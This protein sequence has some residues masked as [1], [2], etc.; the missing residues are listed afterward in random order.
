VNQL[1]LLC[2]TCH[3]AAHR[4]R[5]WPSLSDLRDVSGMESGP[6][7]DEGGS[8]L[9]PTGCPPAAFSSHFA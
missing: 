6:A 1:A 4:M 5:P 2:P 7:S 9:V 3:R 8:P